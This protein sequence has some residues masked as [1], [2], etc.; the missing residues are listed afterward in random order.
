M[1]K[2]AGELP[3]IYAGT[4]AALLYMVLMNGLPSIILVLPV[5]VYGIGI[6]VMGVFSS[7]RMLRKKLVRLGMLAVA[8]S[9]WSLLESRVIQLLWGDMVIISYLFFT[10]FY[11]I[12][13]LAVSFLLTFV[14]LRKRKYVRGLFWITSAFFVI[15]QLLQITSTVYYIQ[16]VS[17]AHVLFILIILS[18]VASYFESWWKKE[19]IPDKSIYRAM[20]LLGIFCIADIVDYYAR[21][22][23]LVGRFSKIGF[24]L[25]FAYLGHYA[26][27][28]FSRMEIQDA[29]KR[30]YQKLAYVDMMTDLSNR[31]AFEEQLE[32]YR[33][34]PWEEKTI[35]LISDMNWLK[36]INDNYGHEQGDKALIRIANLLKEN[37]KEGC[38]CYRIGGDEFAVISRGISE[39][40][41][42]D[43]CASFQKDVSS[44]PQEADWELSV[45]CGYYVVDDSGIDES[46]KKAD[47]NMYKEKMEFRQRMKEE[48]VNK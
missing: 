26:I 47:A 22:T 34:E 44:S 33:K 17:V 29:E 27:R 43:M 20:I 5:L 10:C 23:V 4:K 36:Y 19:T 7:Q 35:L 40:K 46:Y 39:S 25:F 42:A 6:G 37:F 45:S 18:V 28:Q 16:M 1:E 8:T 30:V 31:T 15:V 38:T 12:P 32:Q 13:V 41:F 48:S 3:T 11:L 21:P 24:L 2:Y 9:V 14:T